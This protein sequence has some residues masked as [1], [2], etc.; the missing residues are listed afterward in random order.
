[1][2][3]IIF[4]TKKC[5]FKIILLAGLLVTFLF[6]YC[7]QLKCIQNNDAREMSSFAFT[8]VNILNKLTDVRAKLNSSRSSVF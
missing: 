7:A 4:I 3:F 8:T 5:L 1:M 6:T 2:C